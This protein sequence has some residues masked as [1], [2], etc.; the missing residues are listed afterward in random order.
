MAYEFSVLKYKRIGGNCAELIDITAREQAQFFKQWPLHIGCK[1]EL[2]C[3][4]LLYGG[5]DWNVNVQWGMAYPIAQN[6]QIFLGETFFKFFK[7]LKIFQIF[8]MFNFL[9]FSQEN[10]KIK[11]HKNIPGFITSFQLI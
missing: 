5:P 8:K 9:G 1:A 7:K 2:E 3:P 10:W 4:L 6:L 11:K